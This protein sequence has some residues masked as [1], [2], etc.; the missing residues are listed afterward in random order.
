MTV[1]KNIKRTYGLTFGQSNTLTNKAKLR[2]D[3]KLRYRL[4]EEVKLTLE[5]SLKAY[6]SPSMVQLSK[7]LHWTDPEFLS[8]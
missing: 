7:D 8:D 4:A 2:P 5:A 1:C 6:A 3:E